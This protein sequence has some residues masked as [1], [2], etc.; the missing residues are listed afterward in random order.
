MNISY[1]NIYFSISIFLRVGKKNVFYECEVWCPSKARLTTTLVTLI[2]MSLEVHTTFCVQIG[3][4]S[5]VA[6]ERLV[7]CGQSSVRRYKHFP[8]W[9]GRYEHFA[10]WSGRYEHFRPIAS[11]RRNWLHAALPTSMQC[12]FFCPFGHKW[13]FLLAGYKVDFIAPCGANNSILHYKGRN[14]AT[15]WVWSLLCPSETRAAITRN[16]FA[17][18]CFE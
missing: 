15:A 16:A 1:L 5:R 18:L 8:R 2:T 11:P 13:I 4:K 3:E 10:R 6:C 9:S 12:D 17:V 14:R 7:K